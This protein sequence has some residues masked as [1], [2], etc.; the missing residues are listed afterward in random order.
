MVNFNVHLCWCSSCFSPNLSLM[1]PFSS[2]FFFFFCSA[3]LYQASFIWLPTSRFFPC[4]CAYSS[5]FV[6]L[7][8]ILLSPNAFSLFSKE[9][10]SF[11]L[12]PSMQYVGPIDF[13]FKLLAGSP[14][15]HKPSALPPFQTSIDHCTANHNQSPPS[16]IMCCSS[17]VVCLSCMVSSLRILLI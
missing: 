5:L 4:L 14:L 15:S 1:K 3:F 6:F 10:P 13:I 11:F 12:F 16:V 17:F 2:A 9:L 8:F 7:V